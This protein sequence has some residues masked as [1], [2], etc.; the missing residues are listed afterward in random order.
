MIGWLRNWVDF[1][2]RQAIRWRRKGCRL[3]MEAKEGLF[4]SDSL[5]E[6]ERLVDTYQ[7]QNWERQSGRTDF[8][9]SL[10]YLQMLERALVE[11]RV[12]LPDSLVALDAGCGDWFYVQALYKL[13]GRS[14]GKFPRQVELDGVELDAYR[15]YAGFHSRRDWAEAF[16]AGLE[17]ARYIPGDIRQYRR[18]VDIA[19]LLFPFLFEG[20]LQRWGLPRRFL[21]P[22]ELLRHVYGLLRPGGILLIANVGAAER[23]EQHRLLAEAGVPIPWWACHTSPIFPYRQERY[24]T[25]VRKWEGDLV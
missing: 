9:A 12:D 15:L 24:I 23:E 4:P 11:A 22:A 1:P 18:P 5:A 17:G 8:A 6:A 19:F 25:V 10:F 7:L 2:L 3:P 14:N 16:A 21:R 20:E 13:L